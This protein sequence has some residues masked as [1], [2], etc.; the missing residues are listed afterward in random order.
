MSNDS[1]EENDQQNRKNIPFVVC[2]KITHRNVW[3]GW[4]DL[5][6]AKTLKTMHRTISRMQKETFS[7]SE[8]GPLTLIRWNEL[9]IGRI[10]P[11][12][13]NNRTVRPPSFEYRREFGDQV[14]RIWLAN[15]MKFVKS[16]NWMDNIESAI[17]NHLPN[18][19]NRV[20]DNRLG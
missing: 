4:R 13:Q 10:V 15:L 14:E 2:G 19:H 18:G 6:L 20:S 3:Y 5:E 12:I 8:C 11:V 1:I 17:A 9:S 7:S 16:P